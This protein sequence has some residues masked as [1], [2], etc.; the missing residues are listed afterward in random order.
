MSARRVSRWFAMGFRLAEMGR[1]KDALPF[2]QCEN[3]WQK[4]EMHTGYA[5][6]AQAGTSWGQHLQ[7]WLVDG[8][9]PMRQVEEK[10]KQEKGN[11]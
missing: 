6:A 10:M 2:G 11:G 8:E 9:D 1:E 5:A 4:E 3:E 7:F